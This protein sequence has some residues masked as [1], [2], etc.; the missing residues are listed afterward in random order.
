MAE[1]IVLKDKYGNPGSYSG[2]DILGVHAYN[3]DNQEY[4]QMFTRISAMS[5]YILLSL[6]DTTWI[7]KDKRP[8]WRSP[9]K[10]YTLCPLSEDDCR[11][12]GRETAS[13]NYQV[14][15]LY[16]AKNLTVGNTY[17]D[18]ELG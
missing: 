12:Y 18:D 2:V 10:N 11:E 8:V 15:L 9:E 6:G 5:L 16:S 14:V 1:S 17:T 4:T 13:G 7:V 3:S